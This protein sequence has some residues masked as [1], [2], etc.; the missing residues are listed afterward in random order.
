MKRVALACLLLGLT[1]CS[2]PTLH[3]TSGQSGEAE[4]ALEN[5]VSRL[6]EQPNVGF[7]YLS[8]TS[9]S[10]YSVTMTGSLDRNAFAWGA[11]GRLTAYRA[12]RAYLFEV[13]S[14]GPDR[15]VDWVGA[16]GGRQCW[17]PLAEEEEYPGL[18]AIDPGV[19]RFVAALNSLHGAAW[20][21]GEDP[22]LTAQLE[23]REAARLATSATLTPLEL[24]AAAGVRGK[25][26]VTVTLKD[27]VLHELVM[28]GRELVL[29]LR[30]GD[31]RM[32][33]DALLELESRDVRLTFGGPTLGVRRP[34]PPGC[35]TGCIS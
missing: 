25:V 34:D 12:P 31:V 24:S 28:S 4:A 1:A 10:E 30:A 8:E 3:G 7:R 18:P 17:Y 35:S 9:G 16:D 29:A 21:V 22:W 26:A 2:Q 15:W 20:Q 6:L 11:E 27:G 23:L 19:P 32:T 33:E 13:R 5:G 14:I